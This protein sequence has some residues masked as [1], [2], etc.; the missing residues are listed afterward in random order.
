MCTLQ[1]ERV[2]GVQRLRN[3]FLGLVLLVLAN[4]DGLSH[5]ALRSGRAR[6]SCQRPGLGIAPGRWSG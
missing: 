2:S 5:A 1:F 3:P 4:R 6:L